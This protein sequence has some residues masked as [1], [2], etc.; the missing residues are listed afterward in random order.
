[1]STYRQIL[2]ALRI[3]EPKDYDSNSSTHSITHSLTHSSDVDELINRLLTTKIHAHKEWTNYDLMVLF[4]E[5]GR[6][7]D[8]EVACRHC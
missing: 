1:M 3:A 5:S 6:N 2:E 4:D 8:K 7:L